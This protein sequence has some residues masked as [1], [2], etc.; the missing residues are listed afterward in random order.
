MYDGRK[1]FFGVDPQQIRD[2]FKP[3]NGSVDMGL[4]DKLARG[5][6]SASDNTRPMFV[7]NLQRLYSKVMYQAA[8]TE[9]PFLPLPEFRDG[10]ILLGSLVQGDKEYGDYSVKLEQM[11]MSEIIAKPNAGKTVLNR[12]IIRGIYEYNQT[13][14]EQERISCI[15]FDRKGDYLGLLHDIPMFAIRIPKDPFRY[16]IFEAPPN[17]DPISYI[18]KQSDWLQHSWK[19]FMRGRNYLEKRA[20]HLYQKLGTAPSLYE[21]RDDITEDTKRADTEVSRETR[22]MLL[23]RLDHTLTEFKECFACKAGFKLW[24][25]FRPGLITLVQVP[26]TVDSYNLLFGSFL[27]YGQEYRS[28]N[29]IRGNFMDGG[30]LL[31]V[32]ESF[33]TWS[34]SE[35]YSDIYIEQ[36][37]GVIQE[38]PRY[39]RD[40][41]LCI[42]ASSQM[43]LSADFNTSANLKIIGHLGDWLEALNAARSCG[44]ETLVEA[45]TKLDKGK[46]L[47]KC[48][49]MD[50]FLLQTEDYPRKEVSEE[51]L[52]HVMKPFWDYLKTQY[53]PLGEKDEVEFIRINDEDALRLIEDVYNHPTVAITTHYTN[54]GLSGQK[55]QNAKK[56]LL[57]SKLIDSVELDIEATG[58]KKK[59]LVFMQKGIEWMERRG[60]SMHYFKHLGHVG[61]EHELTKIIVMSH[62]KKMGFK[63]RHDYTVGSKTV[64]IFSEL[65][66]QEGKLVKIYE[67]CIRP[68]INSHNVRTVLIHCSEFICLCKDTTV[69]SSIQNQLK[70]LPQQKVRYYVISEFLRDIK[71]QTLDREPDYIVNNNKNHENSQNLTSSEETDRQQHDNNNRSD[72]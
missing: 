59:Y 71:K 24:E 18:S 6:A 47:V 69:L 65:D 53:E 40:F 39:V 64:D 42:V 23:N 43:M 8:N 31:L 61:I 51:H 37:P 10:D 58:K 46:F 26:L 20:I 72:S 32:D 21:L 15:I 27:I 22:L 25:L 11:I 49:T 66:S 50:A 52:S 62:L 54:C 36:G 45:I 2:M 1:N 14:P 33:A 30:T 35:K 68:A 9:T 29:G 38:A 16:S 48:G 19:F 13:R 17:V 67:I 57:E 60:F 7:N 5:M 56:I 4:V 34:P 3:F 12:H 44:D 70:E 63:V 28:N 41:K 55:A